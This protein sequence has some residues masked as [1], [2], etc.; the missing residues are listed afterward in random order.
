MLGR[1]R[2]FYIHQTPRHTARGVCVYNRSD[3]WTTSGFTK[4]TGMILYSHATYIQN[5]ILCRE[6]EHWVCSNITSRSRHST[7]YIAENSNARACF[8][9]VTLHSGFLQVKLTPSQTI[10]SC[11]DVY[12]KAG[13]IGCPLLPRPLICAGARK[14][15]RGFYKKNLH[16]LSHTQSKYKGRNTTRATRHLPPYFTQ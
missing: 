14:R 11:S 10:S 15:R 16:C 5:C 6:R 13:K 1:R 2:D 9:C 3:M 4:Y 8:F 7:E 12:A